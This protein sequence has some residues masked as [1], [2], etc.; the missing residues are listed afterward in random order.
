MGTGVPGE[1]GPEG[2]GSTWNRADVGVRAVSVG[3]CGEG[4]TGRGRLGGAGAGLAL[5]TGFQVELL[6]WLLVGAV[7]G[8]GVQNGSRGAAPGGWAQPEV[9]SEQ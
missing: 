5:S 1:R 3:V 8:G 4:P 2:L 9:G 7:S 6:R